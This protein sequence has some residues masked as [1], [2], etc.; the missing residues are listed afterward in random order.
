MS[1]RCVAHILWITTREEQELFSCYVRGGSPPLTCYV[2]CEL[3]L[4]AH[5]SSQLVLRA[6]VMDHTWSMTIRA[7]WAVAHVDIRAISTWA[8]VEIDHV[9]LASCCSL[10]HEIK[11]WVADV[12]RWYSTTR[13]KVN[14]KHRW[15]TG[16]WWAAVTNKVA[17]AVVC[18]TKLIK[19]GDFFFKIFPF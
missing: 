7:T 4:R 15:S 14:V 10:A 1:H 9:E 17:H 3:V 11:D 6:A 19:L 2:Q 13:H 18:H 5:I 8:H 12:S 16:V